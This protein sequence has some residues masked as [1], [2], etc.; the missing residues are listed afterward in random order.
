MLV[1]KFDAFVQQIKHHGEGN[2]TLRTLPNDKVVDIYIDNPSKRNCLS[3]RMIHQLMTIIDTLSTDPRYED[4]VTLLLRGSGSGSIDTD[5]DTSTDTPVVA[6][7]ALPA[8]AF[9]AGLDFS[10]AKEVV[11]SPD[12]GLLMCTMMTEALNRLRALD[13]V[14]VAVIHGP[15][16]GGG[17]ELAT[18][19]DYRLITSEATSKIGFVHGR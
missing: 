17:A 19:C 1:D 18:A 4:T 3:G 2:I 9:C 5:T 11:N 12:Q 13:V 10:L 15:A 6:A 7:A 14:S 16:L 8:P